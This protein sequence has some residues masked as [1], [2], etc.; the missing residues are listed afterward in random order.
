MLEAGAEV[1]VARVS[2]TNHRVAADRILRPGGAMRHRS[3]GDDWNLKSRPNSW[4]TVH[5]V[6]VCYYQRPEPEMVERILQTPEVA[7]GWKRMFAKK[8][9]LESSI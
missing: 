1:E 9:G 4:L 6:N 2:E 5:A 7:E 8:L 3:A